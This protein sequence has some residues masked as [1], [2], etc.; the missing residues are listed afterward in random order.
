M[1]GCI[2]DVETYRKAMDKFGEENQ[3]QEEQWRLLHETYV[4]NLTRLHDAM[5]RSDVVFWEPPQRVGV[6]RNADW[7]SNA[8]SATVAR[9]GNLKTTSVA[10]G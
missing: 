6:K 3:A 8:V 7:R 5:Q 9:R 4:S 10:K 2:L 1:S